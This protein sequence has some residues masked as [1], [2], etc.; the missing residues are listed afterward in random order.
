MSE[1]SFFKRAE[2]SRDQLQLS[3]KNSSLFLFLPCTPHNCMYRLNYSYTHL[4]S[5]KTHICLIF[6][7]QKT[8]KASCILT[9]YMKEGEVPYC[10]PD[11]V[12]CMLL[13]LS[14]KPFQ[15]SRTGD[16]YIQCRMHVVYTS[17]MFQVIFTANDSETNCTK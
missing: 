14:F 6:S 12:P 7:I 16:N 13:A 2:P 3:H 4:C 8:E 9:C 10:S 15:H 5:L 17:H 1:A 11:G